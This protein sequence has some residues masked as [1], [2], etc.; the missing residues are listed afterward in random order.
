MLKNSI[1]ILLIAFLFIALS[2]QSSKAAANNP[3]VVDGYS[4]NYKAVSYDY[5]HYKYTVDLKVL[6]ADPD[7]DAVQ[8]TFR[9]RNYQACSTA[10]TSTWVNKSSDGYYHWRVTL[11]ANN[12]YEYSAKGRDEHGLYSN[13]L[14]FC[15]QSDGSASYG[16]VP[17]KTIN[18]G[19]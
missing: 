13:G 5:A 19:W 18:E 17:A 11:V 16:W 7:N 10:Q 9:I 1:K 8:V 14:K 3:P 2:A 15:T 12:K 4:L 6:A